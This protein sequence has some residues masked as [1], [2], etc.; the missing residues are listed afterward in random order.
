[1]KYRIGLA[2]WLLTFALCPR[3]AAAQ[4]SANPG[5]EKL[6]ALA[7]EWDGKTQD[8]KAVHVSYKLVS[9]GTA[10]METLAPSEEAQMITMYHPDGTSVGM[11]HYCNENNQPQMRTAP[12][13]GSVN[14]LA[15]HFVRATNLTSPADGHMVGLVMVFEDNDHFTQKWTFRKA[16]KDMTEA[17][18]F[19]RKS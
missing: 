14:Q 3:P 12:V 13:A 16:G 1:M 18:R 4:A 7:G 6:K 9:N 15:F 2:L 19:T 10:L 5:F 17:V 11:T 8:G